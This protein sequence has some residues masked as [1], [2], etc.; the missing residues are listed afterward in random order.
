MEQETE[1]VR[2]GMSLC[3]YQLRRFLVICCRISTRPRL[4]VTPMKQAFVRERRKVD[5]FQAKKGNYASSE[6][7]G[8]ACTRQCR[9][10][11]K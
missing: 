9:V 11:A 3:F 8:L 10:I 1:N 4:H 2:Y 5:T 7:L 6:V